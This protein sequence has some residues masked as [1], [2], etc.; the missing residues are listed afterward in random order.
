MKKLLLLLLLPTTML[1]SCKKDDVSP[2]NTTELKSL[3]LSTDNESGLYYGSIKYYDNNSQETLSLNG[4]PETI[5]IS[6]ID[7]SKPIDIN[8]S[9]GSIL[10]SPTGEQDIFVNSYGTF[11]LKK[12]EYIIDVKYTSHYTYTK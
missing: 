10:Y 6:D 3:T 5:Y 9:K 4:T 2:N 7:W 8:V 12:G 11:T 1:L